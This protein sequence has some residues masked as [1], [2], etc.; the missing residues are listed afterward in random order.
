VTNTLLLWCWTAATAGHYLLTA[1]E[2]ARLLPDD[3]TT[4]ERVFHAAVL[5]TGS[6]LV[7]AHVA[8]LT[9]G[10][11]PASA[12]A[13]FA[14]WHA[15]ALWLAHTSGRDPGPAA[16]LT[17]AESLAVIA[18]I[19]LLGGWIDFAVGTATVL[20]TDAAHYHVPNAV[21]LAR[22]S[23]VFDLPA[24][25]H[26][27]PIAGSVAGAWFIAPLGTPL[28]VDLSMVLPLLLLA[29]SLN[30]LF[31]W[32]TGLSGL[33]WASD[34]CWAVSFSLSTRSTKRSPSTT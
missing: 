13:W 6:L 24:S 15:G 12:V 1:A 28:L 30:V 9:A 14:L 7:I 11:G 27:Y 18:A 26:L 10:L 16:P 23:G 32:T 17:L 20:G 21:N 8:A 2:A 33:A 3:R 29:A 31:Q 19:G 34:G 5:G 25:P 4:D 22:G